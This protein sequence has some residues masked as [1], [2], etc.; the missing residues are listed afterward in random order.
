M[1]S[2]LDDWTYW[3]FFTITVN[4]NRSHIELLLHD[5]LTNLYEESLAT[6]ISW[7]EFTSMRTEYSSPSRTVTF[8]LLFCLLS[9]ESCV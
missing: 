6:G 5:C 7:T 8:P 2:G 3:H 1:G 4:Y 9:R